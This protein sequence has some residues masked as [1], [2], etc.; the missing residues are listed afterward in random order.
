MIKTKSPILDIKG[1]SSAIKDD[2]TE[3][4]IRD[5]VDTK[6]GI[7]DIVFSFTDKLDVAPLTL[8]TSDTMTVTGLTPGSIILVSAKDGQVAAGT[9]V[10]GGFA[11]SVPVIASSAGSIVVAARGMSSGISGVSV[12]VIVTVGTTKDAFVIK[13]AG[14]STVPLQQVWGWNQTEKLF[15]E[16]PTTNAIMMTSPTPFSGLPNKNWSALDAMYKSVWV[17]SDDGEFWA[18]GSNSDGSLGNL[19]TTARSSPAMSFSFPGWKAFSCG[20][21]HGALIN[22]TGRMFTWGNGLN[23]RLGHGNTSHRSSPVQV[24]TLTNWKTVSC[25]DTSTVSIKTD[26]T[27]WKTGVLS[28]ATT[29]TSSFSQVG[30]SNLWKSVIACG[31]SSYFLARTDNSVWAW[32]NNTD[33]HLGTGDTTHRSSPVQVFNIGWKDFSSSGV[34]SVGVKLNGSMWSWGRNSTGQLGLG[35]YSTS[36]QLSPIQVGSTRNW[37]QVTCEKDSTYAIRTDGT[38]WGWG[39]INRLSNSLSTYNRHQVDQVFVV[40][41]PV[42]IGALN[43][44]STISSTEGN[45][46]SVDANLGHGIILAISE[47]GED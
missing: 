20:Q 10:L 33:G 34:H 31:G 2:K 43:N 19:S 44:W 37:E 30:T 29:T 39:R 47:G 13:T 11:S 4:G 26:G 17:A 28:G 32:G 5:Y 9:S 24:G 6:L 7:G 16:S 36:P 40:N 46:Y 15:G 8:V 21:Y 45:S 3:G 23:G 22:S 38:L 25:G 18:W 12:N 27:L 42:Q 41:S 14:T 35:T 1:I